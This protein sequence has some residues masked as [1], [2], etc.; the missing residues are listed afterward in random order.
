VQEETGSFDES[1]EA[2][3]HASVATTRLYVGRI[4]VKADKHSRKVAERMKAQRSS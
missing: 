2:L 1:R 4:T 3:D